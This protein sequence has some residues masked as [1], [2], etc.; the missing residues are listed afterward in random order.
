MSPTTLNKTALSDRVEHYYHSTEIRYKI[1]M[2]VWAI[3]T[4]FHYANNRT[5]TLQLHI[6]LLNVAALFLLA[7][8]SSILRL[9][10]FI[11]LQLYEVNHTLPAGSNHWIFTAFV[12]ITILTALLTQVLKTKSFR[13]D[14]TLLFE[15]F[16]PVVRIELIILYFFV[17]FHKLNSGFFSTELSCASEFYT[18][19]NAYALLPS[20]P[21]ILS[22]NAYG[23]IFVEAL[24]PI[25]LCF[26]KTRNWGLLIGLIFHCIIAYSPLNGFY[27]FSSLIFAIYFLFTSHNFSDRIHR[28]YKALIQKKNYVKE[29]VPHFSYAK[30]A[31]V[32]GAVIIGL[33]FVHLLSTNLKDYFRHVLWTAYSFT[34]IAIFIVAMLTKESSTNALDRAFVIPN[35]LLLIIPFLVFLNGISPYLGLKTEHSFAMFSNLRTEGGKTN[36]YIVPVESQI[37]DFQKDMVQVVSSSDEQLNSYA[38]KGQLL[39]YHSFHTIVLRKKVEE[40]TYLRNG[41][42][43]KF[44]LAEA[45]PNHPL[46]QE[47]PFLMR[48][49]M[50]FRS[51]SATEPQPCSH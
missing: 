28:A 51:I 13:V 15:T 38:E 14:R 24:I 48:K 1:F 47:P 19:Q 34:F 44:V 36:H 12:N 10:I 29:Q 5:F 43:Q 17:V 35:K 31:M 45:S 2:A 8:P 50:Q 3:A 42:P 40:V 21:L 6:F 26:R 32:A 25:L 22:L 30:L 41:E 33:F 27:D 11:A 7:K 46:L 49:F 37:F 18:A 16:A 9:V 23:T 39:V 4:F 20:S